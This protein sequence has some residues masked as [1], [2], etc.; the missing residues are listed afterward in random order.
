[1]IFNDRPAKRLTMTA[2]ET[3]HD[4]IEQRPQRL[5]QVVIPSLLFV[6]GLI[7]LL[8]I[9]HSVGK[10]FAEHKLPG[11]LREFIDAAEHFGTPYG[12]LLGLLCVAAATGWQ[13]RRVVRIFLGTSIAGLAANVVKLLIART[14]PRAFDFDTAGI[15]EGFVGLLPLGMGGSSIQSFPS[16]HTASAFGFAALLTWAFPRGRNTFI[17]LGLLVGIHRISTS[18]HY[19]SDVFVGAAVGWLVGLWFTG[20]TWPARQ[21][22]RLEKSG[23]R[24]ASA[25]PA[26]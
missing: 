16:A 12:Q 3:V 4:R 20:T 11:E 9:D 8:T 2:P 26:P 15:L 13:E 18:A 7:S 6:L 24:N 22:D 14:R 23:K 21:F 17:V 1:M 5:E 19:P 25:A 10:Y